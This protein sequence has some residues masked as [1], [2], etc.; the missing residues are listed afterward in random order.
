M[1]AV[2]LNREC[3]RSFCARL[4]SRVSAWTIEA[5]DC[6]MAEQ[7]KPM[8]ALVSFDAYRFE[9]REKHPFSQPVPIKWCGVNRTLLG[10][11]NH[12]FKCFAVLAR[13]PHPHNGRVSIVEILHRG[14]TYPERLPLGFPLSEFFRADLK[15]GTV[16]AIG[17]AA[18]PR[19][20]TGRA[21]Q[22][23]SGK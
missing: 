11:F 7:V 14:H 17:K 10:P 13:A 15:T 1:S 8:R 23:S 20:C 16:K 6:R 21:I 12:P 9:R 5:A 4:K 18:A 22:F 3:P 19:S 2:V